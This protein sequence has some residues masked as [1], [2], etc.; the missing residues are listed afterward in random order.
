M[1][2]VQRV[3]PVEK[4]LD[5]ANDDTILKHMHLVS[6]LMVF[7]FVFTSTAL[8]SGSAFFA[9][10][11]SSPVI[12]PYLTIISALHLFVLG[13]ACFGLLKYF[14]C[15]KTTMGEYH[16]DRVWLGLTSVSLVFFF[17]QLGFY[18]ALSAVV[19]GNSARD[20]IFL[21][22]SV[23]M[24]GISTLVATMALVPSIMLAWIKTRFPYK[25]F[26]LERIRHW[27]RVKEAERLDV[28]S[29][30]NDQGSERVGEKAS[31]P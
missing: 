17:F 11:L 9:M 26:Y 25:D 23:V 15:L 24:V 16:L 18:I 22:I 14:I 8:L 29:S 30:P 31:D 7:M 19:G 12:A 1:E 3:V 6:V 21:A 2:V 13:V 4:V 28:L 27:K 20:A 5:N 10:R